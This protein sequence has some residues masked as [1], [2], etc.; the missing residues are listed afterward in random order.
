MKTNISITNS[1]ILA[2]LKICLSF[3]L[4][5]YEYNFHCRTFKVLLVNNFY[6]LYNKLSII[7]KGESS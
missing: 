3:L 6:S 7:D 4:C 5:F 2:V 1:V